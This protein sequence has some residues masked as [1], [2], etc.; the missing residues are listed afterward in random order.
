[1]AAND[2][3]VY[4]VMHGARLG[5]P[6]RPVK[7]RGIERDGVLVPRCNVH[8]IGTQDAG[9][10]RFREVTSEEAERLR[11]CQRCQNWKPWTW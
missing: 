2:T 6:I 4:L 1:M 5:K 7:H 9:P 3:E 11:L 10:R 8:N